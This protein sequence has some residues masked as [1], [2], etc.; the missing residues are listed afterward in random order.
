MRAVLDRTIFTV[1][2]RDGLWCVEHE[3]GPFGH[4]RD[5]EIAKAAA[6]RRAREM[7]DGGQPC[8]VRVFGEHGFWGL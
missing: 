2:K 5:K 1:V 8:E 7:F 6:H 3:A 4:S